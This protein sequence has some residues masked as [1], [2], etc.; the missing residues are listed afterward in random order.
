V[1][2][3]DAEFDF[4]ETIIVVPLTSHPTDESP[5]VPMLLPDDGN[6]L[7]EPSRFMAHRIGAI[8]KTDVGKVV[9]RLSR[10][11]IERIDVALEMVLGLG[12][13]NASGAI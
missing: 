1:V 7:I 13:I 5:V 6:G 9:G 2:V 3:Q 12:R 4:A 10:S 8:Y 11:D